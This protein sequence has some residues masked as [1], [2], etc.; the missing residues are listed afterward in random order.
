MKKPVILTALL[1]IAAVALGSLALQSDH[2]QFQKALAKERSEGNL[3]EAIGLY[4]KIIDETKDEALAAQAQ[5][6]VG[7][8]YEKLGHEKA[9]LAQQAFQKVVDKYPAQTETARTA[10]ERLALLLRAQRPARE[11]D[12]QLVLRSVLTTKNPQVAHQISPDGRSLA[13]FD[14]E[15]GTVAVRDLATGETRTLRSRLTDGESPGECWFLRWSPD[16]KSVVCNWWHDEPR[17]EWADFRLVFIDGSAPR[18]VLQGDY[19]DAYPVDWTPDGRTILAG[20]FRD[21]GQEGT[22]MAMVSVDDGSVRTLKTV[23]GRLGNMAFSPDGRYIAYDSPSEEGSDRRDIFVIPA[24]GAAG[25]PLITHP[26]QDSLVGWAPDGKQVLFTSDRLETQDLWIVP[27]A[28]GHAAGDPRVIKRGTGEISSA[29]I[30]RS[31]SLYFSTSNAMTDVYVIEVDPQTGKIVS[32]HKKM[33]LP[34]QG[35]NRGPEYSPDGRHLAY[36]RDSS[37]GQGHSTLYVF[38]METQEERAFPL[39]A[40]GRMP[41]WSPD[42]RLIYLTVDLGD[43]RFGMCRLDLQTGQRVPVG[44]EKSLKGSGP[45]P[46]PVLP[47]S[48]NLFMGCSPSGESFYFTSW[49]AADRIFRVLVRDIGT[50]TEKELF[51]T[52]ES[53][54]WGPAALSPDGRQLAI[55]SRDDRRALMLIPTS[56]G[57]TRALYQFDQE[58]GWPTMITWTADS[59]HILFS[60]SGQGENRGWSLWRISADGGEPQ[61]LGMST[62]F[63][64]WVCAHPDGRRV[65]FSSS[66]GSGTEV[67]VLE[68]FLPGEKAKTKGE[69]Q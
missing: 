48:Y 63:I 3:E 4:Q 67:W 33:D 45:S 46:Q 43:G 8:C 47:A 27:F 49:K 35:S 6:R 55:A 54:M 14:Y 52:G 57:E 58:G 50:G 29:G 38:S 42:G 61:D 65:A 66:Q 11:G 53:L 9:Q 20:L 21:E 23:P 62:Q 68:N 60:R 28:D 15:I 16:G 59:R 12:H 25:A 5:L 44:P 32:P 69:S 26:A 39:G 22:V 37:P 18:R 56:G 24:N 13:Y 40:W 36:F 64:S 2:D 30:T 19:F 7:F 51:R 17:L 34:R 1:M 31:G 10:R 41:R